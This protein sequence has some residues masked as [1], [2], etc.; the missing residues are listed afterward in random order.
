MESQEQCDRMKQLCLDNGLKLIDNFIYNE[1]KL[2]FRFSSSN[3][4]GIWHIIEGF[5]Q[6]TEEEFKELLKTK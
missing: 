6:L 5:Q 1:A 4:Y 2:C 3:K